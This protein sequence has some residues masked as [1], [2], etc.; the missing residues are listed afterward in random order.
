M[1]TSPKAYTG[2]VAI[3]GHRS[4]IARALAV[5]LELR[6]IPV[7]VLDKSELGTRDL[8]VF[9]CVYLVL[10]RSRP[11][12]DDADLEM[13]QLTAFIENPHG[14]TRT[15]YI[16]SKRLSE[17]KRWCEQ[18][19]KEVSKRYRVIN[20]IRPAAVFGPGQ[21]P[22]SEMLVPSLVRTGGDLELRSP[23]LLTKFISTGDLARYLAE[24]ADPSWYNHNWHGDPD[25]IF[26]VPGTFTMTPH[27][28][29][30]LYRCF[31]GLTPLVSHAP[32][33]SVPETAPHGSRWRFRGD[34]EADDS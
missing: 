26:D 12:W 16:S 32:V 19:I 23:D 10:G 17:C 29:R 14:P 13:R 18:R 9:S 25:S 7:T 34:D 5:E 6:G 24:F 3:A 4:F 15:V 31:R 22:N 2:Q 28:M 11:T 30:E 33:D 1:T 21:D 20:V 27:D 8:S